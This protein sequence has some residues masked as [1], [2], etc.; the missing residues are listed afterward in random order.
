[1]NLR[2]ILIFFFLLIGNLLAQDYK[3]WFINQDKSSDGITSVG[4]ANRSP[5]SDTSFIQSAF[6]N[7]CENY[8]HNYRSYISGYKLNR[9][10]DIGTYAIEEIISE[11]F[12]SSLFLYAQS[13]FKIIDTLIT[14]NLVSVIAG[15]SEIK[16]EFINKA[17]FQK[18]SPEWI[19]KLPNENGYLYIVGESEYYHYESSSWLMAE[20]R[21]RR[22]FAAF[23]DSKIQSVEK[24]AH[25]SG[26]S[27][28]REYFAS[29]LTDVQTMARHYDKK[30]KI[31]YVLMRMKI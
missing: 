23:L 14:G 17:K 16:N 22:Y 7:A 28:F 31:Y 10:T 11:E 6:I 15:S 24:V 2:G 18:D 3:A 27:L 13:S 30:N 1:M 4:Y 29:D 8:A 26:D 9:G 21:G 5:Q 19:S 25:R 20:K 12:D